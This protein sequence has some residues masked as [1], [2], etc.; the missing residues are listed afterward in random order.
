MSKK[1]LFYLLC[2]I[3]VLLAAGAKASM[4]PST[5]GDFLTVTFID[6]GQGDSA[7]I[8]TPDGKSLLIDGGEYEAYDESLKPFLMSQDIQSVDYALVSHY[9]SDHMGGISEMLAEQKVRKLII[10]EYDDKNQSREKLVKKANK[11][12]TELLEVSQGDSIDLGDPDLKVSVLHP[13]K[14]GFSKDN[15]NSNSLVLYVEYLGTSFLF[16][17]DL[18]ADA[19]ETL[20]DSYALECDV[21]KAG[22]HGSSTSTSEEFLMATNPTYAVISAGRNNRYGHPHYE[23]LDL[24]EN[25]DVKIYRTDTDGD[26]TF[27]VSEKGIEK[28]ET[29]RGK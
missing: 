11:N 29:E 9:H 19:E 26:I 20:V 28:I 27:K 5:S 17:G 3:A 1:R 8:K 2:T 16:T 12:Q 22:H 25:D 4:P 18:E 15:E 13:E 24:L 23:T 7:L 21:L 6:V 10:P 14:G